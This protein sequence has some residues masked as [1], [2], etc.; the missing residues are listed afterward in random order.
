VAGKPALFCATLLA[1]GFFVLG[2]SSFQSLAIF[3]MLSGVAVLLAA[4]SELFVLPALLELAH[5]ERAPR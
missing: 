2:F 1:L 4:G 3:G 5:R